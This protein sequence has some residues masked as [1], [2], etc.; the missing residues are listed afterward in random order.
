[1]NL[2]APDEIKNLELSQSE[3][4]NRNKNLAGYHVFLTRF[5]ADLRRLSYTEKEKIVSDEKI[6]GTTAAL[7]VTSSNR[8]RASPNTSLALPSPGKPIS[9]DADTNSFPDPL[10]AGPCRRPL[11]IPMS[12]FLAPDFDVKEAEVLAKDASFK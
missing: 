1:M 7:L 4:H 10:F 8:S 12:K 5:I 6:R 11:K 9:E 3:T 2:I